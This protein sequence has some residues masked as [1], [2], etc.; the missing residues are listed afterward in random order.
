MDAED[1]AGLHQPGGDLPVLPAGGEVPAWVVMGY[2]D[3]GGTLPD[4]D[5]EDLRL[6]IGNDTI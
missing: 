1:L 2:D 4:R 5:G 3:G 6:S